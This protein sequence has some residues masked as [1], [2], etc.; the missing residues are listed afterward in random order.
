MNHLGLLIL[1]VSLSA[2]ML[3]HGIPKFQKLLSGDFSFA[4]PIGIGEFPSLMVTVI[5]E[6][7]CPILIIIGYKTKWSSLPIIGVMTVAAFV[8]HAG[9]PIENKE[10]A[11]LYLFGFIVVALS[12][13]GKYSID[14]S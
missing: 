9:D 4:N 8:V 12:G 5:G 1:R 2:L 6:L 11:L 3:T 10:K 7:L 13:P 14:K